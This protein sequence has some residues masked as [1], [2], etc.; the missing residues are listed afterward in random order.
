MAEIEKKRRFRVDWLMYILGAAM[1]IGLLIQATRSEISRNPSR[2]AT[3]DL[4]PNGF[5]TIRFATSPYPPLPTGTVNL[6]FMPMNSRGRPIAVDSIAYEYGSADSEQPIG[7]GTAEP[8]S[9][10]SGM[11]MA[12]ARFPSVGDWWLRARVIIGNSQ[13]EA[14]FTFYVEPAQ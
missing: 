4:G 6:T 9:D 13:G 11:F 3:I 14:R 1:L 10:N 2:D 7:S 8:M 12:G 5:I